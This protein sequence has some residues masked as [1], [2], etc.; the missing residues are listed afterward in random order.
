MRIGANY[1]MHPES[2]EHWLKMLRGIGV[3]AAVFPLDNTASSEEIE[4]YRNAALDNGLIIAEVGVWNNC[5]DPNDTARAAAVH[6]AKEQLAL[7]EEIGALCCVNVSGARGPVWDGCYTD[8]RSRDTYA[9]VVDTVR[10]IIDA[11]NPKRTFYTLEPLAWMFPDS[12]EA[13]LDMLRDVDR[14]AFAVHMDYT[15]FISGYSMYE[16]CQAFIEHCFMKLAPYIKSVHAKD[17]LLEPKTPIT[18]HEVLPGEGIVDF[19]RVL[20]LAHALSPDMPVLAEHLPDYAAC[21]AAA[22]HL[23]KVAD[24]NGISYIKAVG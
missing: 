11:V 7:A 10:E 2:P 9:L 24:A 23:H 1:V 16:N 21:V 14:K 22:G 15:N 5:I 8:N 17:I 19:A 13:Y 6:Y 20:R 3:G 12:P 4:A 18:I